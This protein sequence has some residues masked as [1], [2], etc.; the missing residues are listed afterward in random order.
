M[1]IRTFY[2][3]PLALSILS[4][5]VT[6]KG[7]DKGLPEVTW[8]N[9]LLPLS[10]QL[11]QLTVTKPWQLNLKIGMDVLTMT[12]PQGV[13]V[14]EFHPSNGT[15]PAEEHRV[16][17]RAK[18][19]REARDVAN[20][21]V[22]EEDDFRSA[23]NDPGGEVEQIEEEVTAGGAPQESSK[24]ANIAEPVAPSSGAESIPSTDGGFS[25]RAAAL[26][27]MDLPPG[28]QVAE[29]KA[30]QAQVALADGA[31]KNTRTG[32][33]AAVVGNISTGRAQREQR[34]PPARLMDLDDGPQLASK[35]SKCSTGKEKGETGVGGATKG[36]ASSGGAPPAVDAA[37]ETKEKS[38]RLH[39]NKNKKLVNIYARAPEATGQEGSVCSGEDLADPTAEAAAAGLM[40]VAAGKDKDTRKRKAVTA[41]RVSNAKGDGTGSNATARGKSIEKPYKVGNY[42]KSSVLDAAE[43][44][45]KEAERRAALIRQEL[46]GRNHPI[47]ILPSGA[48]DPWWGGGFRDGLGH[49]WN[50]HDAYGGLSHQAQGMYGGGA[51]ESSYDAPSFGVSGQGRHINPSQ[52]MQAFSAL[53]QL[54]QSSV[55]EI[56]S[57]FYNYKPPA[58]SAHADPR[59]PPFNA[60]PFEAFRG[61]S[62]GLDSS[63]LNNQPVRGM[64]QSVGPERGGGPGGSGGGAVAFANH[65]IEGAASADDAA[66]LRWHNNM[67]QHAMAGHAS[68]RG[69]F[70]VDPAERAMFRPPPTRQAYEETL[71][72]NQFQFSKL[73]DTMEQLRRVVSFTTEPVPSHMRVVIISRAQRLLEEISQSVSQIPLS[74][75][76]A[77]VAAVLEVQS[78]VQRQL[79][80][81]M[82]EILITKPMQMSSQL[83]ALKPNADKAP[84]ETAKDVAAGAGGE[85][86]RRR[87]GDT[88]APPPS[89]LGAHGG[90][91]VAPPQ[92]IGGVAESDPAR[93]SS[94]PASASLDGMRPSR[95]SSDDDVADAAANPPRNE[96][97]DEEKADAEAKK[98]EEQQEEGN[99]EESGPA[100]EDEPTTDDDEA[101][102]PVEDGKAMNVDEE[103]GDEA[104]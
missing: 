38:S 56:V 75:Q 82:D 21:A 69:N 8:A 61:R 15:A 46:G 44:E 24:L 63:A 73:C 83:N 68:P 76:A 47:P 4:S 71:Q 52:Q 81:R 90:T 65:S 66:I 39:K 62:R 84:R 5:R 41:T 14:R 22:D 37:K 27:G 18:Q 10:E 58:P 101:V 16:P 6:D 70:M 96:D 29:Q 100:G 3:F 2:T 72:K 98:E 31:L 102:T 32:T 26:S 77:L 35:P 50:P 45:Q 1:L 54:S 59:Y 13:E 53:S 94:S 95:P 11:D 7:E 42:T 9:T 55:G 93:T 19:D 64:E 86:K 30:G 23:E 25:I 104:D 80:E 87:L 89:N 67:A 78:W 17:S 103:T 20:E 91:S 99:E 49:Q 57:R 34:R 74:E 33:A 12:V 92:N 36:G 79:R 85:Q 40:A 88:V 48:R 28:E 51:R 60:N 97:E 43:R